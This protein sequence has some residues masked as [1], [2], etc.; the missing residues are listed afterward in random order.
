MQFAH[1]LFVVFVIGKEG[2]FDL[3]YSKKPLHSSKL[4]EI[5]E[6]LVELNQSMLYAYKLSK[7]G[8][9]GNG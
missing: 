9:L 2:M 5:V 8:K 7:G 1:C 6:S 4:S 3:Q